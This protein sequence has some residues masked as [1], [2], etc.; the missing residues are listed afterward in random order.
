MVSCVFQ[1][2]Y[3]GLR[4]RPA[5]VLVSSHHGC[6]SLC[7]RT[8]VLL[9]RA[10]GSPDPKDSREYNF[11]CIRD[12]SARHLNITQAVVVSHV[13]VGLN[14]VTPIGELPFRALSRCGFQALI[15]LKEQH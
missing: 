11:P 14:F 13:Q 1:F 3:L 8:L 4:P 10:E 6:L 9:S 15:V 5:D 12:D 2:Q 7:S